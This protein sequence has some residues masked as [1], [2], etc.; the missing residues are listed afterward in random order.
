MK[1][2]RWRCGG[3][4]DGEFLDAAAFLSE[5]DVVRKQGARSGLPSLV[6]RARTPALDIFSV[7]ERFSQGT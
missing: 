6:H 2:W 5:R 7:C 3:L 1:L 4:L